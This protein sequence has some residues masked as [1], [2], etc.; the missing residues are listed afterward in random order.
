MTPKTSTV[1]WIQIPG[2]TSRLHCQR[3]PRGSALSTSTRRHPRVSQPQ[4]FRSLG[5]ASVSMKPWNSW[6]NAYCTLTRTPSFT[7]RNPAN[8]TLPWEITSESSPANWRLTITSPNSCR[9]LQ[10]TMVTKPRR[11]KSSAK[12]VASVSTV[13]AKPS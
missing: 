8:P 9:E 3:P 13:R 10:R 7:W 2:C 12:S 4:R 1:S 6:V 11:V 5:H